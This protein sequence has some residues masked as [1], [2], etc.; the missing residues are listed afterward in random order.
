MTEEFL[1]IKRNQISECDREIM[2]LLRKRLDLATEIGEYKAQH[3]ME[4]RNLAV[5]A[6]VIERYR[7]YAEELGMDPDRTEIICRIIM[8][9]SVAKENVVKREIHE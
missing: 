9:E 5:E 3:G 6:K 7:T 4:V 8:Q 2:A 1:E